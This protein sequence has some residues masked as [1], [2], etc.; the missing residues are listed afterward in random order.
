MRVAYLGPAGT[1]SDEALRAS[2]PAGAEAIPYPTIY[3]AVIA[4]QDGA[5][6]RAIV[7][8]ENALEGGVAVAL[9]TL[10]ARGPPGA[11]R[12]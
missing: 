6:D 9:D 10:D 8:I 2:A 11:D 1:H 5:V 12:G 7:P 4:V 3:D